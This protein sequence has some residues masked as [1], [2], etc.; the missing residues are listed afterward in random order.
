METISKVASAAAETATNVAVEASNLAA[1]ASKAAVNAVYGTNQS[2]E[3]PISGKTGDVS[4]GEPYDAGNME[5]SE[6]TGVAVGEKMVTD[7]TVRPT[8]P[9]LTQ[10]A[11]GPVKADGS[12]PKPSNQVKVPEAEKDHSPPTVNSRIDNHYNIPEHSSVNPQTN[13]YQG[14]DSVAPKMDAHYNVAVPKT[15]DIKALDD[16]HDS[17]HTSSFGTADIKPKETHTSSSGTADIKPVETQTSNIPT[18]QSTTFQDQSSSKHNVPKVSPAATQDS[19]RQTGDSTQAQNDIRSP[20]DPSTH[21]TH[22][23]ARENVDDRDGG[24]DASKNPNKDL[25]SGPKP[26]VEVAKQH[27]GDAGKAENVGVKEPQNGAPKEEQASNPESHHIHHATG[28]VA[29]GGDFDAAAPGAGI[30]AD[31]LLESKGIHRD[32]ANGPLT[33]N[34]DALDHHDG[35]GHKEKTS[36]KQKIKDKLHKH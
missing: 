23:N 36:L 4:K 10:A 25:G 26:L 13:A 27:G 16:R 5:P 2:H 18:E 34:T 21:P 11:A 22:V 19:S 24:L 9:K 29:D 31:R 28:F 1:Q 14:P 35:H 6:S 7:R 15:T 12:E 20:N 8:S 32:N 17:S 33:G 3:E 30:E